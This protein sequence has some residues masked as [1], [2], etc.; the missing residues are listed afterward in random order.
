MARPDFSQ[1]VV[2]LDLDDTL[3][4]EADYHISGMREVCTWVE[5]LYGKPVAESLEVCRKQGE[6][7]LLG[8]ISR[9]AN[10][11][12]VV[13]E[14]LLW[15]Y[16][17]HV[18]AISISD[19]VRDLIKQLEA[20]C[21]AVAILTDGRSVS[22]R[23][24]LKALGLAHLPVYISEEYGSE[25]P[26]GLRFRQIMQDFPAHRYVYVGDN[27]EKDFVAPNAL[28]WTTIGLRGDERNIHS[29]ECD[30]LPVEKFPQ[31]WIDSLDEL[32]GSIC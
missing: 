16:R 6:R 8:A 5:A 9:L 15:I 4:K 14:S 25:K 23:Q 26:D 19:A 32:L 10:L 31:Q 11:P 22:Q 17:L 27:P 1:T 18:P 20:T 24:K 30:G 29:Q 7:D 21:R 3:Y 12:A 28:N 13:K 2:V